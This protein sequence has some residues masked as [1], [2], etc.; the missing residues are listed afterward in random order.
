MLRESM[1]N[2]LRAAARRLR[3]VDLVL[4]GYVERLLLRSEIADLEKCI[5]LPLIAIVGPPRVGS[6]L[7]YQILVARFQSFYYDNFQHAF[8]RY[9]YLSFLV[10]HFLS[11]K[12]ETR[13]SSDHGFVAGIT[14][15]SEGN[16]FWP[17]WFDMQMSERIPEPQADCLRH[18]CRVLNRI[19]Q[20]TGRPMVSSYNAHAYYLV[21]LDRL[22]EKLVIINMRRDP[23]ANALS[24]LRARKLLRPNVD[25]WWSIQPARCA[26]LP[27]G[28]PYTKIVCQIVETY[29][30]IN[31][32]RS[33]LSSV[34]IVDVDYDDL[35][36]SPST[37]LSRVAEACDEA[38]IQLNPR[39]YSPPMPDLSARGLTE[40]EAEERERFQSLF[41][42]I[43]WNELW[44]RHVRYAN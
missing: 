37:I 29:R 7:M 5:K 8:L 25:Q 10:S 22:F 26:E 21:E 20:M 4:P 34:P 40:N 42:T 39:S 11:P 38:G 24:L 14:G 18:V 32:Q 1:T 31:Q 9:P 28:D 3:D 16:F 13:F 12:T 41:N 2:W 30:A 43:D 6:T 23:V 36:A 27:S 19:H 15:L 44:G 17:F 35:C 33:Q